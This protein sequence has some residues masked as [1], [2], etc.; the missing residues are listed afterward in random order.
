MAD[1]GVLICGAGPVG[2]TLAIELARFGVPVRI[3]D[4]A[5]ARTDRSKAVVIWCRSLELFARAGLADSLV[6]AGNK[7]PHGSIL[8][9]AETIAQL[10][11]AELETPYPFALI[12]PQTETERI[13]EEHLATLGVSVERQTEMTAFTASRHRRQRD[14]ARRRRQ[15]S[16]RSRPRGWPA[17]TGRIP[18]CAMR[19]ASVSKARP[20]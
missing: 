13:L 18:R 16:G 6:A 20:R 1:D 7:V 17:A 9:G 5:A 19:S 11:F 12:I 3:I 15:P 10:D 14:L 4:K 2:L 8:D